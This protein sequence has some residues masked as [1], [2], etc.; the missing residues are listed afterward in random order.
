MKI[1]LIGYG[2]MGHEIEAAGLQR[3]HTFPVIIDV[4]N[5]ADLNR[6]NLEKVDVAIDFS[7]PEAAPEHM[8][9]CF[10]AGSPIVTGTTGWH[11]QADEIIELC[12]SKNGS[13][14]YASNFSIGVNMLFAINRKLADL[15]ARF[16]SYKVA[17]KEVH[18]TRKLDAPSGTAI[19]L[20]SQ[21]IERLETVNGWALAGSEKDNEIPVEAIREDDVK[22]DHTVSY[23]SDIDTL[24]IG[25]HAK[26]RKGFAL[27][28]ILAAEFLQGKTG[29]YTMDDLLDLS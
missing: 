16:G 17:I 9:I 4:N 11:S 14:F 13:L 21:I 22:G 5:Q 28:A 19:T 26:N 29:I 15:V 1:A 2:S 7:H 12:K 24:F 25:H 8:R 6:Q 27:G 18:H 23:D 10:E 3:G 20:A